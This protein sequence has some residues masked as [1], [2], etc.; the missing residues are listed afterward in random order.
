MVFLLKVVWNGCFVG[1]VSSRGGGVS[2]GFVG[3]V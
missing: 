1:T 2:F 3:F